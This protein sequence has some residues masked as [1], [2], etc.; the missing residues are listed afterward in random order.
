MMRASTALLQR[1]LSRRPS[2]IRVKGTPSELARRPRG[3]LVQTLSDALPSGW[4]LGAIHA[5]RGSCIATSC[6]GTWT[7]PSGDWR[8]T[9][10]T[11]LADHAWQVRDER[12]QHGRRVDRRTVSRTLLIKGPE[13]DHALVLDAESLSVNELYVAITRGSTSLTVLSAGPI[14]SPHA[15]RRSGPRRN[16]GVGGAQSTRTRGVSVQSWPLIAC[17]PPMGARQVNCPS[18]G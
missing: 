10:T 14:V 2:T 12:R 8:W 4:R 9:P 5:E 16:L 13:F 18:P 11:P 15:T 7:E 1:E 3:R 17:L 6:G